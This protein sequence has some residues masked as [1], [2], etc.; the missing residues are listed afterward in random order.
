MIIGFLRLMAFWLVF[1]L[2]AR[3][4]LLIYFRS[5]R[6]E[7]LEKE[8][9]AEQG[10]PIDAPDRDAFIQAGM[11][12]FE[13]SLQRRLLWGVIILPFVLIG[14]LLFLMNFA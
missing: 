11:A 12:E 1:A 14:T 4:L 5:L 6:R 3:W 8:W 9:D 2:I 10:G 7:A 13:R